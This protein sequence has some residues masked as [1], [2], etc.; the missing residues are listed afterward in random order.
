MV[1]SVS[2][3]SESDDLQITNDTDTVSTGED[4]VTLNSNAVMAVNTE[5]DAVIGI[6]DSSNVL[7]AT[8]P[9]DELQSQIDAHYGEEITLQKNYVFSSGTNNVGVNI[10]GAIT[11]NGNGKTIDAAQTG[12]IFYITGENVVIKNLT[13][14]NG[15]MN[16]HG[17]LIYS[18]AKYLT[19]DHC[20]FYDSKTTANY[21]FGGAIYYDQGYGNIAYC[22]FQGNKGICT[23]GN[24]QGGALMIARNGYMNITYSTFK[25]NTELTGDGDGGAIIFS[26][27]SYANFTHCQFES[28]ACVDATSDVHA[29]SFSNFY[30]YNCTFKNS[31]VEGSTD[32]DGS[33]VGFNNCNGIILDN[34]T[35][36]NCS[37]RSGVAGGVYLRGTCSN[38]EITN[39]FF[40]N[41]TAREWG[42]AITIFPSSTIT[43]LVIRNNTFINN[44]AGYGGAIA[45]KTTSS[46]MTIEDCKFY[47][48]TAIAQTGYS[49]TYTGNGG[50]IY[51]NCYTELVN[52]VFEGNNANVSG[53]AVYTTDVC[54][55]KD[56]N[57]T[58][59]NAVVYGGAIYD[60]TTDTSKT[61]AINNARFVN[62]HANQNGGALYIVDGATVSYD[63][64][65]YS[66][67]TA[68]IN[69]D[70]KTDGVTILI[71]TMYVQ[72]GKNG[73]GL[74]EITPTNW[75]YAFNNIANEGTL[76]LLGG[77]EYTVTGVTISKILT[78]V[79]DDDN[80]VFNAN[81]AGRI[82]TVS[83]R[84]VTIKNIYFK[85]AYLAGSGAAISW[86]GTNGLLQDCTFDSCESYAASTNAI[87]SWAGEN[88]VIDNCTL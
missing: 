57:F 52:C 1:G 9:R 42:G 13:L 50:A 77:S 85:N 24:A 11:I 74:S 7:Q 63:D 12:R 19:V 8:D 33:S 40:I 65:Y 72:V 53:G 73:D 35:W 21:Q 70:I 23:V 26:S 15:Q 49:D 59:N 45:I 62:N 69:P 48:N 37:A 82:F 81:N 16:A 29:Y 68:P 44:T 60:G 30:M 6:D 84:D 47:N 2:A 18:G 5:N 38:A 22:T 58:S 76:H 10:T 31:Y 28:N 67:N 54:L 43:N 87:V 36:I 39:S 78:I 55:I 3:A 75:T 46:S 71:K 79:G 61:F 88:G 4:A 27:G 32:H 86:S 64:L 17:G 80:V 25:E 66:G 56:S 34:C 20:N 83:I 14:K 41:N 51:A